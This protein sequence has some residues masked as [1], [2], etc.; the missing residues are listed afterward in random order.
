VFLVHWGTG[1]RLFGRRAGE[2]PADAAPR[3]VVARGEL[4]PDEE[5]TIEVYEKIAPSVVHINNIAH[6][7]GFFDLDIQQIPRGS[8]SGFVWDENGIIVTNAHVVQ[9]ADAVEVVLSDKERSSYETRVWVTYPDKDLAVLHVDAPRRLLPKIPLIGSSHDLRIGQKTY[10]IGNPFGLDQTLTT[11]VV[12]ALN[13]KIESQTGRPIQ[14]VIQTS[15][16]I[17][18]GNSGG[19][20]LDSAGRLIGVNTA[21]LSPSGTF[22]GI[23]FA[24][25]VDEVNRVVPSLIARLNEVVKRNTGPEEVS[26]PGLGVEM[27][28]EQL[29]KELGVTQGALIHRVRPGGA[30][31]KA[32][33]RGTI[34]DARSR[35][36][37]LGDVITAIGGEPINSSKD[38]FTHLEGREVGDTVML[39]I[40]RN[41][42]QK[43]VSVTLAPIR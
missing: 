4:S 3:P 7:R 25:P 1:W 24:I 23:G 39:T 5:A 30:A 35:R 15:A 20:L 29:A 9:D 22:A 31:D 14:G 41:G 36:I 38:I 19:P 37:R 16:A 27:V 21:I 8:G 42:Q 28:S 12:S 18:P 6:R 2:L 10:A 13:R 34:Q 11:G 17:N 40:R 32:G 43:E 26:P 33:L